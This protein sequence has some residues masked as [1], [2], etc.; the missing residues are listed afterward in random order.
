MTKKPVYNQKDFAV[1]G[2][3]LVN[4]DPTVAQ[5][6]HQQ[7]F[8]LIGKPRSYPIERMVTFLP[9]FIDHYSL[10]EGYFTQRYDTDVNRLKRIF[11]ASMIEIY[12]PE[13]FSLKA[14]FVQFYQKGFVLQ[15]S[16]CIQVQR[17]H[18]SNMIREVITAYK[19]YDD[20]RTATNILTQILLKHGTK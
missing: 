16:A 11:S 15:L 19:V 14:D 9:I 17:S 4:N 12:H 10:P 7:A 1:I 6:L 2:K 8:H 5:E 20:F 13:M 3:M 18:T